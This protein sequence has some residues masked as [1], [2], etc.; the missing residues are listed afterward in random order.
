[1]WKGI[2][3][4][5]TCDTEGGHAAGESR[6]MSLLVNCI[7]YIAESITTDCRMCLHTVDKGLRTKAIIFCNVHICSIKSCN[8]IEIPK[9]L[10]PPSLTPIL[11]C[12]ES[13][14]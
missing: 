5:L 10:L 8:T 14:S 4:H 1:M 6:L 9:L 7:L 13:V 2:F 11:E 3:I 12:T